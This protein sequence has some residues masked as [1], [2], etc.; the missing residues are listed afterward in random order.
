MA[1]RPKPAQPR[2]VPR[3]YLVTPPV[4]DPAAFTSELMPVIEAAD[5]AAVLLRLAD[6]DER[7]LINRV[8]DVA[9][10]VQD[11]GIALII[12]GRPEI[13]ARSGADGS[14]LDGIEIFSA[15]IKTLK[16]DRIAGAGGL[17][18]RHDAMVA[19]DSGAD[20]VLFGSTE[21]AANIERVSWCAEVLE[22]PCVAFARSEAEVGPLVEAGADFIALDYVWRERSR[23]SELLAAAAHYM[24]LPETA[25]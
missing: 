16:P 7:T 22:L 10:S 12:E 13:V 1:S 17:G 14:H 15:A 4:S 11:R 2:A 8:K 20:Y 21:E 3:F 25:S 6:A 5:V 9:A 19:A 23:A 18:T 24:R